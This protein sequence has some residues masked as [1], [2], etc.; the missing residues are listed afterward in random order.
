MTKKPTNIAA[1]IRAKLMNVAN[2]SKR[3]FDVVVLQYFQERFLYRLAQS[4]HRSK[5]ILKGALMFRAYGIP[6]TRPTKDIDFLG[7]TIGPETGLLTAIMQEILD[8]QCE[9]G[10]IFDPAS[11]AITSIKEDADYEGLRIFIEGKL[12]TIR[13]KIQIDIGF[14]DIITEGPLEMDYPVILDQPAPHLMVYSKETA[15]AEKFEAM[16]RLGTANSRMKDFYDIFYL[17][18]HEEFGASSLSA[19]IN[20]TFSHRGTDLNQAQFIFSDDF[21]ANNALNEM[22]TAFLKRSKLDTTIQFVETLI[23]LE[24]FLSIALLPDR[25]TTRWFFTTKKWQ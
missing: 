16:V 5:L 25:I 12:D 24:H 19:A 11:I 13:K 7:R 10:I 21:K 18:E 9:D 3:A 23:I 8:I 4:K 6:I 17:A 22:W 15:I 14:G 2:Q 1:S 20:Q